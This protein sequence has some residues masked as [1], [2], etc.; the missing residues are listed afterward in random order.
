MNEQELCRKHD[1]PLCRAHGSDNSIP[2]PNFSSQR[3]ICDDVDTFSVFDFNAHA[4]FDV[5][6]CLHKKCYE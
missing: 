2:E 1:I 5:V 3:N 6:C 4:D